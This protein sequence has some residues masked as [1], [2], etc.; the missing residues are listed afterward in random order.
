LEGE[1]AWVKLSGGYRN[2]TAGYPYADVAPLA[3]RFVERAP[4]RCV[5]G[6]D[7]PHTNLP[8]QIPDDGELLSLLSEWAPD[9]AIRH[10]VL[11]DNP[12]RLYGF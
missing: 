3:R 11:V 10:Q 4:T 1:R 7:W 9:P 5:W 6:T 2:S 12:A 8:G